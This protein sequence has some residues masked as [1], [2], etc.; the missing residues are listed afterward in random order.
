[1]RFLVY[2]HHNDNVH[3]GA[4]FRE[5][6]ELTAPSKEVYARRHGYDFLCQTTFPPTVAPCFERVYMALENMDRYDW[7]FYTDADAMITNQDTRLE[8]LIDD[9]YDL[10]TTV[11]PT[12]DKFVNINNGVMLIK[13]SEWSRSF[14]KLI[15]SPVYHSH[16]WLSQQALIDF[17]AEPETKSHIKLTPWRFFNSLWHSSYGDHNW[18]PG[19]F[20]L[21]A[22]GFGNAWRK[23]LFTEITKKLA[24]GPLLTID[25]PQAR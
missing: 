25:T 15:D 14:L 13:C 24:S 17:Y 18:Q 4:S 19:D 2:T 6:G 10:I 11:D 9:Q 16:P 1:M 3:E 7:M 23:T 12:C 5:I 21:H 20:V 22:A 8:N